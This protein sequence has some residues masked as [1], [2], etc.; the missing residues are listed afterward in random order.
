M[1]LS[2]KA[3]LFCH[4]PPLPPWC[5]HKRLAWNFHLLCILMARQ[6]YRLVLQLRGVQF[7]NWASVLRAWIRVVYVADT[8][9]VV[10]DIWNNHPGGIHSNTGFL[11]TI[12]IVGHIVL[13]VGGCP[14]HCRILPAESLASTQEML[15]DPPQCDNQKCLPGEQNHPWLR[16]IVL[17]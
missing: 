3:N 2:T 16:T 1:R 17:T 15:V 5:W 4:P 13:F 6:G 12:D 8:Q 11:S 7:R 9:G 14:V 10:P